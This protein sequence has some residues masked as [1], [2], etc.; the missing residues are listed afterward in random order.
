MSITHQE[1]RAGTMHEI[2]STVTIKGQVTIPIEIRRLLGV[3]PH[4]HV[5][6]VVEG[7]RVELKRKE[8]VVARTAGIFRD[9]EQ[10]LTAQQLREAGEEA[11][12]ED[13]QERMG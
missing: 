3:K 4:D 6:F 5:T 12:A 2:S 8:S 1:D 10:P 11:I 7:G 9:E 13:A